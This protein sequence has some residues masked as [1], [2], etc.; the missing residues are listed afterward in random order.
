MTPPSESVRPTARAGVGWLAC[1]AVAV[2]GCGGG[3]QKVARPGPCGVSANELH[4]QYIIE[5]A[6]SRLRMKRGTARLVGTVLSG[7]DCSPIESAVVVLGYED[8]AQTS[9]LADKAGRFTLV[10]LP[11]GTAT[12]TFYAAEYSHTVPCV[13]IEPAKTVRIDLVWSCPGCEGKD[14]GLQ[15][16]LV[17]VEPGRVP[18]SSPRL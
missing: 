14:C 8:G 18:R 17:P 12:L 6:S 10:D 5:G 11:P 1:C 15:D 16:A 2:V 7:D 13:R 3:G 4:N 9:V